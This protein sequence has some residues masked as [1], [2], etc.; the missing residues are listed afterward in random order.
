MGRSSR[1]QDQDSV[2]DQDDIEYES[3][4]C[5]KTL[6]GHTDDVICLDFNHPK[7]MLISSSM[8]GSVK[9]WDLYRNK[10]LGNLEG[11]QGLVQCLQLDEARLL[12]GAD[13]GTIKQWDLSLID[14]NSTFSSSV[15]SGS[16][17]PPT[18][19]SLTAINNN[20]NSGLINETFTLEGHASEITAI[21]ADQHSIVSGSNDKTIKQWDIETQQNI[22]TLD[23]LWASGNSKIGNIVDSWL[24]SSNYGYASHDYVGALQFWDFALASGTSDGKIRMWDCKYCLFLCFYLIDWLTDLYIYSKNGSGSSYFTWT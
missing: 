24:E 4:T 14:N 6:E 7:G 22:L 15:F 10:C 18:S 2:I 5:F 13:D 16:T 17:S 11:H 21:F 8:D 20:N 19:P 3:G 1:T 12:T 9:A 23:V